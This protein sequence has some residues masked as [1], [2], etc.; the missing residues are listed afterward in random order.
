MIAGCVRI[1]QR[2]A[3]VAE[4]W[5]SGSGTAVCSALLALLFDV[6]PFAAPVDAHN[7]NARV[8]SR[9]G[10]QHISND[11]YAKMASAAKRGSTAAVPKGSAVV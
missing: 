6:V 7:L 2:A 3:S 5:R 1:F 10:F 9:P 4:S 11:V 8:K